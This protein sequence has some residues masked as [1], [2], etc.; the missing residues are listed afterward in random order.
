M[1]NPPLL[2]AVRWDCRMLKVTD[3]PCRRNVIERR[4][5]FE[6]LPRIP[7]RQLI[8]VRMLKDAAPA[9]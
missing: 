8:L 7:A 6:V 5:P 2:N 4:D 9:A 1:E 3:G